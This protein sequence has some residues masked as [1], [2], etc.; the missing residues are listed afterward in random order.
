MITKTTRSS[1]YVNLSGWTKL[2][3]E[4]D[5]HQSPIAHCVHVSPVGRGRNVEWDR[6]SL[7]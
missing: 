4:G 3:K 5:V 7:Q 6:N 1:V 2:E